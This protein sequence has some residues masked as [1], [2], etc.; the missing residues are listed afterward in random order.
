MSIQYNIK[1]NLLGG[2]LLTCLLAG[3]TA[4]A[5]A[6]SSLDQPGANIR[7]AEP[8]AEAKIESTEQPAVTKD[9]VRFH[10][11][12][13]NIEAP[14]L[15]LEPEAMREFFRTLEGRDV[16]LGE[17]QAAARQLTLYC[18]QNGYPASIAY[19]P[20]QESDDAVLLV[21]VL[22]GRYD[23]ITLDNESRLNPKVAESFLAGLRHGDIVR[24]YDLETALFSLSDK[25]GAKAVGVMRPG[26]EAGSTSV[27]V[28]L[29]DAKPTNTVLYAE[30]YGSKASGRYRYGLQHTVYNVGGTGAK[31]NVGGVVSNGGMKNYYVNYEMLVGRGGTT[32]G[33]G[34]SRMQYTLGGTLRAWGANGTADTLSLYGS[35]PLYQTDAEKLS[36]NYGYDYRKLRDDLDALKGLADGKKHS[37]SLRVGLDGIKHDFKNGLFLD[38]GLTLTMGTVSADSAYTRR[39]V[40]ESRSDGRFVKAELNFS[41]VQRLGQST[42]IML[43]LSGQKASKNLDSSEE[44]YLGGANAVRAYP[45]G[46]G[47]GDE[48]AVGTLELRWHTDAP[49]LTLSTYLDMGSVNIARDRREGSTTLYGWGI[50]VTYNSPDNW[51]ARLDYARR[52]G[53]ADIVDK[54]AESRAR[55]WFMVGKT[56]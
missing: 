23:E 39:L 46:A 17:V 32:L 3:G 33:L 48:G 19:L 18:R 53:L 27:T 2:A 10:L 26:R 24:T 41:A 35:R 38:Y 7:Q 21:K 11:M 51:F 20:E 36:V 31:M 16:T 4:P 47:S 14:E 28:H 29:E 5:F 1:S 45:Q 9:E 55:M 37:H 54:D 40:E 13:V 25:S 50:G 56:W 22:P 34:I 43:K 15:K 42:D 52:I 6:A 44:I 30:N 12:R 8:H 49:G